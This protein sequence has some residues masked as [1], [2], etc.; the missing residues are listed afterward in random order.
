M[1]ETE[2]KEVDNF[3][4]FPLYPI[5]SRKMSYRVFVKLDNADQGERHWICFYIKD[6]KSL[7]FDSLGG[8]LHIF[9]LNQLQKQKL[10]VIKETKKIVVD[11]VER[12]YIFSSQ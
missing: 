4:Y 11:Y 6:N 3:L 5:D 9:L 7:H 1:N 10:F 8:Q 2:L 12:I